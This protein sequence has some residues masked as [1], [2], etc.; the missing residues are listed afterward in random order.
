M[1]FTME[2]VELKHVIVLLLEDARRLQQLEPNA[3]TE[4]RIWL[5]KKCLDSKNFQKE[6]TISFENSP[7]L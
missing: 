3:G 6:I 7:R 1:G 4:A 5:A 2:E